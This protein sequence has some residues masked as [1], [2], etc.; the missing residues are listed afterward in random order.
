MYFVDSSESLPIDGHCDVIFL[1]HLAD[2]V[3][4]DANLK[5][6]FLLIRSVALFAALRLPKIEPVAA[7]DEILQSEVVFHI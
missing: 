1:K 5:L 7:L 4:D 3:E 6:D 2:L